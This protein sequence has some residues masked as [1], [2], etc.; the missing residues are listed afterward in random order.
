ME[1]EKEDYIYV[2]FTIKKN[3]VKMISDRK[4]KIEGND[5]SFLNPNYTEQHFVKQYK[6]DQRSA[7]EKLSAYYRND[8]GEHILVYYM[9]L[10]LSNSVTDSDI[11]NVMLL[12][13][14]SGVKKVILVVG[15]NVMPSAIS[16]LSEEPDY[17]VQVFKD[18][19]LLKDP[20]Q[21]M[22]YDTHTLMT[23]EQK[24]EFYKSNHIV[25]NQLPRM[26]ETDPIAKYFGYRGG[27]LVMIVREHF[28]SSQVQKVPTWRIVESVPL[29]NVG[30]KSKQK[31]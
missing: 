25:I 13:K 26:R 16:A 9:P 28:Y 1:E 12:L 22:F 8:E 4:Y 11:R 15:Q 20:T 30:D 27:D 7:R 23:N 29:V 19:E 3:Q 14:S 6:G 31:R 18:D 24:T 21:H 17:K 2:L 10:V 5:A